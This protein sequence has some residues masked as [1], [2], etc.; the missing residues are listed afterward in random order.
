MLDSKFMKCKDVK[1]NSALERANAFK[2]QNP[3]F[4]WVAKQSYIHGSA[5]FA[6][7][8]NFARSFLGSRKNGES[9]KLVMLDGRVWEAKYIIRIKSTKT[10]VFELSSGGFRA[11]AKANDLKVGD[12][13]VFEFLGGTTITFQVLIF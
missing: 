7:P 1:G 6:I 13:C 8:S 3:S 9:T 11:L 12:V 5:N 4:V 10:V 2:S